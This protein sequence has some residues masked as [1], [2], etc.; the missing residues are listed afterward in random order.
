MCGFSTCPRM[1]R[2]ISASFWSGRE[3]NGD[4]TELQKFALENR[5]FWWWVKD[6][7]E[8]SERSIFE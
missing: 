1:F 4:M 2:D 5:L 3:Y 7:T 6:V 8:L